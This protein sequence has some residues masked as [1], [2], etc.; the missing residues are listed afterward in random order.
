MESTETKKSSQ[1]NTYNKIKL[2]YSYSHKD[3]HMLAQLETHLAL[4]KRLGI[5][6]T[7]YDRI[8]LPGQELEKEINTNLE[9]A[10]IILLL[11]SANFLASDYCYEIEMKRALERHESGEACVIPIIISSVELR[12]TPFEGLKFLPEDGRP[13]QNWR[14]RDE[15]WTNVSQGIRKVI[16]TIKVRRLIAKLNTIIEI[17]PPHVRKEIENIRQDIE[18]LFGNTFTYPKRRFAPVFGESHISVFS[19][20]GKIR[21]PI[22]FEFPSYERA[23]CHEITIKGTAWSI[24]TNKKKIEITPDQLSLSYGKEYMWTIKLIK[25]AE[26]LEEE[27]GFFSLLALKEKKDIEQIENQIIGIESEDERLLFWGAILEEKELYIDAIQKYKNL[28]NSQPSPEIAYRI[29]CCYNKLELDDLR[30]KW[31]RKILQM[32]YPELLET[33]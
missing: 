22:V 23:D 14:P 31:N 30:N 12:G 19:P 7:W 3:R 9:Q 26:A 6:S 27:Y 24:R 16:E 28:Y 21:Y 29:A 33:H 20:F 5:I 15:A 13:V 1:S 2:F 32:E 10:D 25:D 18:T 8:I 4:L 17:C 11:I